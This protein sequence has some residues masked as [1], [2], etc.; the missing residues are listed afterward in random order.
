MINRSVLLYDP[1][2]KHICFTYVL[3]NLKNVPQTINN[4]VRL[5][6]TLWEDK[7]NFHFWV[8]LN[9]FF[10]IILYKKNQN[11]FFPI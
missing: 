4:T 3:K 8:Y 11:T 1:I 7:R 5:L 2:Y 9:L 6:I 10:T